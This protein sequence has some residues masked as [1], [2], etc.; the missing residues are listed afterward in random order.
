MGLLQFDMC[1]SRCSY[2][3]RERDKE[4]TKI[5]ALSN[6][7]TYVPPHKD[8]CTEHFQ[9]GFGSYKFVVKWIQCI[10]TESRKIKSL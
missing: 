8:L 1:L 7:H 10:S 9:A 4:V 2:C 5:A 6:F 3:C